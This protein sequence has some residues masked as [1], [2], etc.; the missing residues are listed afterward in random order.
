[1]SQSGGSIPSWQRGVGSHPAEGAMRVEEV[2][3]VG[4]KA[5]L[6][7]HGATAQKIPSCGAKASGRRFES[8]AV[9]LTFKRLQGAPGNALAMV[10][11]IVVGAGFAIDRSVGQDVIHHA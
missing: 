7:A 10:T 6:I 1:M 2:L 8:H 9:A 5:T 4:E 11:V 3:E